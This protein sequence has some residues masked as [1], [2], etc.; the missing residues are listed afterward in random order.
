M[1]LFALVLVYVLPIQRH[2]A[3]VAELISADQAARI[4]GNSQGWRVDTNIAERRQSDNSDAAA[5]GHLQAVTTGI[6]PGL[7]EACR[8]TDRPNAKIR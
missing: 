1:Y 8:R 7:S 4:L 6:L 2:G 5:F 3:Y